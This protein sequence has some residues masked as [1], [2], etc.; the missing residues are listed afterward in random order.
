M[1]KILALNGLI[2]SKF[3]SESKMADAMGWSRQRLNKITNGDKEPDLFDVRDISDIL[4]V[5]FMTVAQIFL[6]LKSQNGD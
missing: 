1:A 6:D 2:H 5:S 4:D 3:D